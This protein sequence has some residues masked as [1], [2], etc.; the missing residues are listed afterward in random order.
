[1]GIVVNIT[2]TDKVYEKLSENIHPAV[3]VDVID[4]GEVATEF[5]PKL[6][7]RLV[8]M[9]NEK[10]TE[11]NRKLAFETFTQSLHEKASLTKR[12]KSLGFTPADGFDLDQMIGVN[13]RLVIQHNEGK[14]KNAGKVYANV[15]NTLK[16]SPDAPKMT[17]PGDYVRK[18]DRPVAA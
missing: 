6:K 1:M 12:V 5:G 4:L 10:D 18:Q 14:G 9:T 16:P 2:S 3:L 7:C 15:A 17:V 8:Y 11:G 13:A